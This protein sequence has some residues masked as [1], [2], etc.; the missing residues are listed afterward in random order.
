MLELDSALTRSLAA[1]AG[2]SL[3]AL[4]FRRG[5]WDLDS[6]RIIFAF[7]AVP[8]FGAGYIAYFVQTL[9]YWVAFRAVVSLMAWHL[10]G[11]FSSMLLYRAFFHRLNEFPGPFLARLSTF[12]TTSLSAKRLHLYEEVQKLHIQYGDY[13]RLG[14]LQQVNTRWFFN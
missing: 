6:P 13:V 5:Q 2:V 1:I 14:M 9:P 7:A 4:V 11:L 8:I 10:A 3:Q 12:Y